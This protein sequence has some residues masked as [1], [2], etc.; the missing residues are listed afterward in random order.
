MV[1]EARGGRGSGSC[2]SKT[3]IQGLNERLAEAVEPPEV[4]EKE[5]EEER[6]RGAGGEGER[7]SEREG[8][9]ERE[10]GRQS[11]PPRSAKPKP[12]QLTP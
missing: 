6:G 9:I 11:K 1:Q 12:L 4:R 8:E 7:E 10:G 2:F 3:Q 5:S